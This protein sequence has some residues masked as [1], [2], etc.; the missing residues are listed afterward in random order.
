M[1]RACPAVRARPRNR[2]GPMN[3][4][5]TL[6]RRRSRSCADRPAFQNQ[7]STAICRITMANQIGSRICSRCAA[8]AA[9]AGSMR[10]NGE[11]V[12]RSCVEIASTRWS[13][14]LGRP[15]IGGPCSRHARGTL[16][17]PEYSLHSRNRPR[18]TY[19]RLKRIRD[20]SRPVCYD[21][22]LRPRPPAAHSRRRHH[23]DA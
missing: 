17:P 19:H 5:R 9:R 1:Q 15:S 12:K 13:S 6:A 14:A 2:S 23:T 21:T 3:S 22:S 8:A 20:P 10:S 4:E 7:T 11:R 18:T 16:F